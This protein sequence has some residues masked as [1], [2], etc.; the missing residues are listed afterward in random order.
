MIRAPRTGTTS[1][2]QAGIA[3]GAALPL[4]QYGR[5]IAILLLHSA[6]KNAFDDE[7]VQLLMHMARN[8][9]FALDN[10]KRESERKIAEEHCVP[11]MH[12]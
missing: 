2:R 8:V 4:V 7:V 1:A 5:T 6:D 9:V 11:P 12:G 10:F 3:V